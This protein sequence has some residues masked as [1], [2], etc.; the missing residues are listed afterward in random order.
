M[1]TNRKSNK[2][3]TLSCQTRDSS[4]SS[5]RLTT[6]GLF[7]AGLMASLVIGISTAGGA[8]PPTYSIQDL[9]VL[10][11]MTDAIPTDINSNGDVVG[12]ASA[13]E[14]KRATE[15]KVSQ[16]RMED[17]GGLGS[18][19]FALN[20]V[21]I[22]VGDST[23]EGP[24]AGVVAASHAAFFKSGVAF[25]LGTL[26]GAL[27]SR[28]NDINAA[29]Q[30]VGFSSTTLDGPYS[31]A[32]V[33]TGQTGMY[34]IGTLGGA[35][36]Q[37]N[38][39]NDNGV[40]TGWSQ[41][42]APASVMAQTHAFLYQLTGPGSPIPSMRDLGT[43]GGFN[44]YGTCVNASNHVVGYSDINKTNN[45]FHGFF[46]NGEK[47]IDLGSLAGN[48]PKGDYSVALGIN[49]SDQVVGYTFFLDPATEHPAQVKQVAFIWSNLTPGSQINK[50]IDLNTLTGQP[51]S[52]YYLF[53]AV[54]I[55]NKGQIAASAYVRG[56][57]SVHTVLLTPI[58]TQYPPPA[59]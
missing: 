47:M 20:D 32:F 35:F 36:A 40:V 37:A 8:Q 1:K 27:Y 57:S 56:D 53:S 43:L 16:K 31:R 48:T 7:F 55:N 29:E 39:I 12:I 5:R 10:P 2:M 42:T 13:G 50:M 21:G 3:K 24:G 33:W 11:G 58:K 34:D 19:A 17:I 25:D 49:S 15:Y 46:Y 41:T 9:G 54:A 59:L 26:E 30:V 38:A 28:A 4:L 44:S 6:V 51:G 45:L 14:E 52:K 23:F 18:R 22:A